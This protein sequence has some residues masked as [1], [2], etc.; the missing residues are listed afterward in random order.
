MVGYH[1]FVLLV[2]STKHISHPAWGTITK[3]SSPPREKYSFMYPPPW[4]VISPGVYHGEIRFLL[5]YTTIKFSCGIEWRI[6]NF[7]CWD[8]RKKNHFIIETNNRNK[9]RSYG[10]IGFQ[11]RWGTHEI[12]KISKIYSSLFSFLKPA[13][14]LH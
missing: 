2:T 11:R 14:W 1:E 13:N 6:F 3:M 5:V 10:V 12:W 9:C 7:W 4:R 8:L